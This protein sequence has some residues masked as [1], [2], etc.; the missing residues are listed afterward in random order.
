MRRTCTGAHWR[1]LNWLCWD[2][3]FCLFLRFV[4][5][6]RTCVIALWVCALHDWTVIV[7]LLL[8]YFP[9]YFYIFSICVLCVRCHDNNNNNNNRPGG[10][11]NSIIAAAAATTTTSTAALKQLHICL[12]VTYWRLGCRS[13]LSRL[14]RWWL[15]YSQC[16]LLRIFHALPATNSSLSTTTQSTCTTKL[17]T[18]FSQSV[19][20]TG[21]KSRTTLQCCRNG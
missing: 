9:F 15:R 11:T 20:S 8:L 1:H 5:V 7:L 2:K 10:L 6:M 3:V 19:H 12:T 17:S 13:S 18:K 16:C 21:W 4:L 14:K